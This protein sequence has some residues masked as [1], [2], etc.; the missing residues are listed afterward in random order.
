[1]AVHFSMRIVKVNNNYLIF[2]AAVAVLASAAGTSARDATTPDQRSATESGQLRLNHGQKWT[3]DAPLRSGMDGIR[4]LMTGTLHAT[5]SPK[6]TSEDYAVVGAGVERQVGRI[7]AQCK[8]AP[9]ADAVLHVII[10]DLMTGAAIMQG[11]T[12]EEPSQGAHRVVTAL[13]NYGHYFSHPGWKPIAG[14]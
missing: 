14:V 11:K 4:A 1:M 3:I 2:V 9:E 12:K 7:V 10:G 6:L 5:Q 8:L 13:N